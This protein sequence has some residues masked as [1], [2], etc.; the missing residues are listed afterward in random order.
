MT[1]VLSQVENYLAERYADNPEVLGRLTE[2]YQQ[3]DSWGLKDN[4]F[5]QDFT[6]GRDEHFY[7]YVWEMLL[8]RHLKMLEL[9]ISSD[10]EGPDFKIDH[11]GQTIWVEAIC[12]SPEGLPD[13]WLNIPSIKK[14]PKVFDVPHEQMLL[15]WTAALKEKKEKL[16][17][18]LDQNGEPKSGYYDN[19]IVGTNEPYVIAINAS[20][21]GYGNVHLHY[22]ISQKPFAL[23]AAFPFGPIELVID[24]ATGKQI[25]Q[26][27]VFRAS[28]K[29]LNGAD[30]PTDNFLNPEYA[31]VSAILGTPAGI[32]AVCGEEAP[33][34]L[35]HNPLA[36]NKLPIGILGADEEYVAEINEDDIEIR[37]VTEEDVHE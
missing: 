5:D 22:S 15:R 18:R 27:H 20:R 36:T 16:T 13:H 3:Y 19:G 14:P 1:E 21:L 30:V 37:L 31:G 17:G 34:A 29:N 23:E 32:N 7:P 28:I 12:P 24:R 2:L 35:V 8:A 6:D 9:D 26:R 10:D 25:D 4:K 11:H 33:I